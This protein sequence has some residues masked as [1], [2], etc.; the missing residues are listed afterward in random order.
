M[1]WRGFLLRQS[2]VLCPKGIDLAGISCGNVQTLIGEVPES[3]QFCS[4]EE[5][6]IS[7]G[8]DK[9]PLVLVLD[10]DPDLGLDPILG[11]DPRGVS[12]GSVSLVTP[13]ASVLPMRQF[14]FPSVL[15]DAPMNPAP[16]KV[17]IG[18]LSSISKP[19]LGYLQRAK[20]REANQLHKKKVLLGVKGDATK[21]TLKLRGEYE[22]RLLI[23]CPVF[24]EAR[25]G[26]SSRMRMWG[27]SVGFVGF[28]G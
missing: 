10:L 28:A 1:L 23:A 26:G 7:S 8:S 22:E 20:D 25:G 4:P 2:S 24:F 13:M 27:D 15:E 17:M 16:A 9:A 14:S 18:K 21:F 5:R 11:Y 12:D 6:L 19:T 3:C